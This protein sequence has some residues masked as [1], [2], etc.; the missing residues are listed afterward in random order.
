MAKKRA[1]MTDVARLAGVTQATVSYVINDSAHISEEVK[2]KVFQ[3]I[4]ELNYTPNFNARALKTNSS[5]IIGIILPDIVNQYYSRMV[6]YL[7]E[8]LI[9]RNHHTMVYTTSYNPDYERDIIQRLLSLD[10]S[11]IIVLYQF[12]DKSNWTLLKSSGK[13]IVALEGGEY[14]DEINIPCIR[15]DSYQAEY[16]ATKYLLNSGAKKI[17]FIHQTAVNESLYNRFL[18]YVQAMKDA[19]L[20]DSSDIYYFEN[21]AEQKEECERIG[22]L[23]SVLPYDAII[24][25]SDLIAVSLI[26][27]LLIHGKKVPDDVRMIGY[28][29]LPLAS[30]FIP[31]LTTIAQPLEEICKRIVEIIFVSENELPLISTTFQTKLIIRDSA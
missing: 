10:V 23:L 27:Q 8:L 22:S 9:Q 6:E 4:K 31:A 17:A 20:F 19:N 21:T 24:A 18:G 5:N 29:N 2:A 13:P 25:S 26:R 14:C 3:A 16:S 28:D 1:T 7:E 30:L 15:T 11:G 12:S